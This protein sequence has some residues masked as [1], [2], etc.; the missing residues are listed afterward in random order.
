MKVLLAKTEVLE[1]LRSNRDRH[2]ET[3]E[4][5]MT[6]WRDEVKELLEAELQYFA[7][8][9]E[10]K[11]ARRGYAQIQL[12]IRPQKYSESY[13]KAIQ[14]LQHHQVDM[15]E[16]EDEDFVRFMMDEWEWHGEWAANAQTYSSK[17]SAF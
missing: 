11:N 9:G 4:Q 17:F 16:L 2:E 12:P 14:M 13:E 15:V 5:A 3:F 10:L 8:K 6:V 7:E 1:K